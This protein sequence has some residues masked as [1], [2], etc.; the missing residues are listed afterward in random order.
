MIKNTYHISS[1][2]MWSSDSALCLW[3]F[4]CIHVIELSSESDICCDDDRFT[5][6]II[7]GIVI[8]PAPHSKD[9]GEAIHCHWETLCTVSSRSINLL[10]SFGLRISQLW[11][12]RQ[13]SLHCIDTIITASSWSL[14]YRDKDAQINRLAKWTNWF[15]L[16]Y[17]TI[18]WFIDCLIRA[19]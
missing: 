9:G 6:N 10:D 12:P 17:P 1:T 11:K 5:H 2:S 16:E 19:H 8:S 13:D 18:T 3:L 15:E 7:N 4:F 14:L